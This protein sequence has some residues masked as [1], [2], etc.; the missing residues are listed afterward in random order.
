MPQEVTENHAIGEGNVLAGRCPQPLSLRLPTLVFAMGR[1]QLNAARP[2]SVDGV[3]GRWIAHERDHHSAT[4][5][6][7]LQCDLTTPA[8]CADDRPPGRHTDTRSHHHVAEKVPIVHE[9]RR[10]NVSRAH[11][12]RPRGAIAEVPFDY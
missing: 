9:P 10:G 6:D 1:Q 12:R 11:Q 5:G 8:A 7:R 4:N 2:A 3:L